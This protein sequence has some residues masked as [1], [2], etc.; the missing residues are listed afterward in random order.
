MLSEA[1]R[2]IRLQG[3]ER[4]LAL[5]ELGLARPK[6]NPR[7]WYA[8]PGALARQAE[9]A[10][11][12]NE[13]AIQLLPPLDRVLAGSVRFEARVEGPVRQVAFSLDGERIYTRTK[14]P[15]TV[16]IDL[17][18]TPLQKKLVAEGLDERGEVVARDEL[19]LNSGEQRF[20]VRLLEPLPGRAYPRGL[21]ARV[22]VD[23]PE[24]ETVERVELWVGDTRVA[25]L[26]QPPY[27]LPL[28]LP[29][30][31]AAGYV[32]AVAYL[33]DGRAAEDVVLLGSA[34][35]PEEMAVRLVDLYT[36]VVDAAGRPVQDLG[37]EAFAVLEDGVRQTPRIFERVEQAPIRVVSLIDNSLSMNDNLA[38]VRSAALQFLRRTLRPIDQAAVITFN[39]SPRLAVGLTNDFEELE[40]GMRG[41]LAEDQTALYD[42]LI[43]SF[44]YLDGVKGRR[45]ILLLSDGVDRISRF[46]FEQTLEAA[47]RAG[48]T[49]YAVGLALPDNGRGEA[50]KKL[51]ALAGETGGRSF[52]VAGTAELD[53]VYAEIERELRAQYRIAYQSTNN[54]P[55]ED[56]RAVKVEL[57][58]KGLEARTISGYYP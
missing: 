44:Q 50:G 39:A 17:G 35:A 3:D 13:P 43:Y 53:G 19:V 56:F 55:D 4:Y 57:K 36:T 58:Q 2:W 37:A 18:S 11:P 26:R 28:T 51:S 6:A 49:V 29:A 52:F 30:G 8:L 16:T 24:G 7:D 20:A 27:A 38:E 45:A 10:L 15:Y 9:P 48:V 41:L 47:R 31:G 25:T 32:R 1:A 42:S 22:R 14:P 54:S 21:R 12:A 40:E 33:K 5:V 46:N 23:T 34:Q